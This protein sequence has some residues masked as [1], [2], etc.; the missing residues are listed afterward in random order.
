M[1]ILITTVR[2]EAFWAVPRSLELEIGDRKLGSKAWSNTTTPPSLVTTPE[3]FSGSFRVS[4][5]CSSIISSIQGFV[6]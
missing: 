5:A 4:Q 3:L 6:R 1:I 2:G